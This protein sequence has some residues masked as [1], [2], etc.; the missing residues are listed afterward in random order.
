MSYV[1]S[2][3]SDRRPNLLFSAFRLHYFKGGAVDTPRGTT[4]KCAVKR[5]VSE[6]KETDNELSQNG[7]F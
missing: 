6:W 5:L 4:T 1:F 7:R 2:N 3:S